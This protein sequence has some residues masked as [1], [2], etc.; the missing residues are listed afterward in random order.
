LLDAITRHRA[1][2]VSRLAQL[3]GVSEM[4]IRR[5]LQALAGAGLVDRFHGGARAAHVPQPET[6]FE[7][8]PLLHAAEKE[9]IGAAA[10]ELVADGDTV[11]LNGGTTTLSVLR[12]LHTRDVC[13]ITNNVAAAFVADRPD[14]EL[15]ILG[16]EYRCTSRS[17]I[18]ELATQMLSQIHGKICILGTNGISAQAG[19]TTSVYGE[20]AI[21]LA[22]ARSCKY[23]VVVVADGSKV[24]RVTNFTSLSLKQVRLLITDASADADALAQ[25]QA[26]GVNTIVCD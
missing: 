4:T 18:G 25:I 8:K 1:T 19:V 5:D 14:C 24:G 26:A 21:N 23:N 17:L 20:A 13:V 6:L 12:H 9:R 2:Q 3:L 7:E 22:M 10:A 16:G 15:I 11:L